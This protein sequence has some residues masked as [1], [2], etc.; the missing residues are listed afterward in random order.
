M[1]TI[2]FR[3]IAIVFG[4]SAI[5]S[6]AMAA[7]TS[8]ASGNNVASVDARSQTLKKLFSDYWEDHL[9]YAPEEATAL[10]DKRYNDRWS[11]YSATGIE[12]S[13]RRSRE[14]TRRVRA[15]DTAGLSEQDKLSAELLLRSLDEEQESIRFKEWQM[16]VN[17]I[18]G[19]HNDVPR[20]VD[21]IPFDDVKDYENYLARLHK[22]PV[23]FAQITAD[24]Q[25]GIRD[26]RVQAKLVSEKVLTQTHALIDTAP[27]DSPFAAPIKKFPAS[28]GAAERKR[29]SGD[30][31]AAIAHDVMP[32]YRRFAEFLRTQYIPKSREQPGID[33]TTDGKAYYDFCIRRSTTLN[34]TADEVHQVGLDE[35]KKDEAEMLAIAKKFGYDDL[36]S[37]NA[38]IKTDRKLH[39]TSKE[40][41]LDL[42]R[43][44]IAQM[45]TKLPEL[46]GTLPKADLIVEAFPAYVEAQSP[47]A[48]YEEG[49]PD[50]KRP[51]RVIVNTYNADEIVLGDAEPIAYHE[52][53]PGHHLQISIAQELTALPEFRKKY[54]NTAY[55]EGWALYSERLGKDLGFYK[56][57]YSD[58][59]R[60]QSDIWR[61][62][63]LVV[64]TGIHAKHW[65]RQQVVDFFH[66]HSSVSET[67]VQRETDRY[68]AW[69]GQALGYKIGQLKL[70]DLRQ[71]AQTRLGAGFDIKKFHDTVIDSGA[72]P[73]NVL[74]ARIDAWIAQTHA[75]SS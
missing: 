58:Y 45:K 65:S 69:P 26:G 35:V 1:S 37:F 15:V 34:M 25:L 67:N 54:T 57:P 71:R 55:L 10:G 12:N 53:I 75:S 20:L 52:G 4:L 8:A 62:I 9:R 29:L 48:T 16:P 56:D 42:Y 19:V 32:A 49:T 14:F 21:A 33:T 36:K 46:F 72:L 22:L 3:T 5:P 70:L 39:A 64:D 17:Q 61:A 24:M 27:A 59:S 60:L 6:W 41:V 51:G 63:R 68:I 7:Q 38:A 43:T 28:V 2:K 40:Q 47:P 74:E 11:D 23:L 13:L 30:I 50:G 73:L 44:D 18:H 66:D 31:E